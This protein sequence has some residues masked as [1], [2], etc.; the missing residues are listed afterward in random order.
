MP[1][2][3]PIPNESDPG[4]VYCVGSIYGTLKVTLTYAVILIYAGPLPPR[5]WRG[6]CPDG[7]II[8][9]CRHASGSDGGSERNNSCFFY[10]SLYL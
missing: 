9:K 2:W 7:S 5:Q 3:N 1:P 4:A 6:E 10:G 8:N